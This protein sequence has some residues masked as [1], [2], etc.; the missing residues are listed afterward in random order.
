MKLM[1][2]VRM[3]LPF[4]NGCSL[5]NAMPIPEDTPPENAQ[6]TTDCAANERVVAKV[7]IDEGRRLQA[8][9]VRCQM[10][11][12]NLI[13]DFQVTTMADAIGTIAV[14]P[15]YEGSPVRTCDLILPTNAWSTGH[16]PDNS[17]RVEVRVVVSTPNEWLVPG[18]RVDLWRVAPSPGPACVVASNMSLT[19]V[20]ETDDGYLLVAQTD[21]KTAQALRQSSDATLHP[22]L[23]GKRDYGT[24]P[25]GTLCVGL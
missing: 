15:I 10:F 25:E 7:R 4:V 11:P 1:T 20:S 17:E 24:T 8:E 9:D 12:S 14:R 22:A 21:P 3:V 18:D 16:N 6:Q 23:R 19:Q 5:C 13:A 2:L